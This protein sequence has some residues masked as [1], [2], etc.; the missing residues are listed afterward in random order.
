MAQIRSID[1]SKRADHPQVCLRE[2]QNH[3]DL[4][5]LDL[6]CPGGKVVRFILG[7]LAYILI[8][9]GGDILLL[10]SQAVRALLTQ[11]ATQMADWTA[12]HILSIGWIALAEGCACLVAWLILRRRTKGQGKA[13]P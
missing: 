10:Q 7:C 4:Y 9:V 5:D 13:R 6:D 3:L 8:L 2:T 11:M 1:A 12:A